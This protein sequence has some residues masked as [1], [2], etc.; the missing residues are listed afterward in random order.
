MAKNKN[1]KQQNDTEF[2]QEVT[3]KNAKQSAQN[4]A[5]ESAD[6]NSKY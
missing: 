3:A 1:K 4:N 5:N 6:N 2:S